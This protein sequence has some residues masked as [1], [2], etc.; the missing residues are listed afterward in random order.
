MYE[1][2][3]VVFYNKLNRIKMLMSYTACILS[4]DK[5]LMHVRIK[6]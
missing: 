5:S 1:G 4:G 2:V 6:K 3:A